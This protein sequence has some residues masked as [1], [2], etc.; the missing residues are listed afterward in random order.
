MNEL[1]INDK[2]LSKIEKYDNEVQTILKNGIKHTDR[3][4]V[5]R[6]KNRISRDVYKLAKESME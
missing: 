1:K 2:I 4:Q 3:A 6:V 5:T